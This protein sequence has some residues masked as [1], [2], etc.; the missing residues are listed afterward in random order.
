ML[1]R[2]VQIIIAIVLIVLMCVFVY[3]ACRVVVDDA[4]PLTERLLE[5]GFSHSTKKHVHFNEAANTVHSY[6]SY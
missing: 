6:Q 3:C 4:P 2:Y 1:E 5:E